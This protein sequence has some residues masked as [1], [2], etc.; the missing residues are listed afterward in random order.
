MNVQMPGAS[1]MRG[2][3]GFRMVDA[4]FGALSKIIPERVMAA[5]EVGNTLVILGGQDPTRRSYVYFELLTGCWGG[6][7]DRDGCDGLCNPANVASNIPIEEA[8]SA[9]PVRIEQYGFADNSGGP[10]KFRGG[11]AIERSWRLLTGKANLSIRS[12]RRDHP[13]YGLYGGHSGQ[14]ST[15]V[16]HRVDGSTTILPV[17]V[18]TTM[19]QGE[20][21]YH[22]MSGAGGW[23]NPLERE[24]S[25]VSDDVRNGKVSWE[26]ARRDY[27]VVLDPKSFQPDLEATSQ[28][29][30]H[31]HAANVTSAQGA[32]L[33]TPI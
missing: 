32:T 2:V 14:P 8:E 10:G 31:I 25:A 18:S 4:V 1:S 19:R 23:G 7:P 22:R 21:L 11:L 30:E 29:R 17:F 20:L 13:P 27:G 3:T 16:L 15:N 24:P 26:S 6:R 28:L 33:C 9:Y 12:D 5:G